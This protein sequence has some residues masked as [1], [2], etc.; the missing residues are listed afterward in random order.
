MGNTAHCFMIEDANKYGVDCA[1]V[2]YSIRFWLNRCKANGQNIHDGR[3]W[4]Y[5]SVPAWAELFPYFSE[6]QI[7][8]ILLKLRTANVLLVGNYNKKGYDKTLWYS[9]NEAEYSLDQAISPD[10]SGEIARPIPD[11]IPDSFF[12]ELPSEPH[13]PPFSKEQQNTILAQLEKAI[14]SRRDDIIHTEPPGTPAAPVS[15]AKKAVSG[16]SAETPKLSPEELLV[17]NYIRDVFDKGYIE[18]NK[19]KLSWDGA[20]GKCLSKIVKTGISIELFRIYAT[21]FYKLVY[22]KDDLVK[23]QTFDPKGFYYKTSLLDSRIGGW[24]DEEKR[25]A[26]HGTASKDIWEKVKMRG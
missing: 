16:Q 2:L 22:M 6:D 19:K 23:N 21:E 17:W 20:Q 3:V 25:T 12:Y 26:S 24:T 8:R 18:I 4:T 13:K 11:S 10:P 1:T 5:N 14:P 7:K 9:V 15:V